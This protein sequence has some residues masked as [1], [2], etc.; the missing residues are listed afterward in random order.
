MKKVIEAIPKLSIIEENDYF[1]VDGEY[2]MLREVFAG[3]MG[4][5]VRITIEEID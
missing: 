2:A 5:R 4:K 3:F 1:E